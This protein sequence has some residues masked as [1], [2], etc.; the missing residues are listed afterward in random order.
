MSESARV[1][2]WRDAKRQKG[3]KPCTLWLTADEESL[4]KDLAAKR[5][6][7]PTEIM[8]QALAYF[9]TGKPPVT[10]IVTDIEQ[11]REMIQAEIATLQTASVLATAIATVTDIEQL[12]A[13][14]QDEL[15]A[16]AVVTATVT[17]MVTATLPALVRAIVEELALETLGLSATATYN[18]Y[19]TDIEDSEET[20]EALYDDDTDTNI[21]VSDTETHRQT[22]EE[23]HVDITDT[24]SNVIDTEMPTAAPTRPASK[25][26]VT[27]V[28]ASA[29][30]GIT[31]QPQARRKGGRPTTIRPRIMDLLRAH[32]EGL[33]AVE[34]KVH[35]GIDKNIGDTLSGMVR[36]RLLTKQG[37]GAQVRY[38]VPGVPPAPLA[39][40]AAPAPARRKRQTPPAAIPTA[41]IPPRRAARTAPRP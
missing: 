24:N 3:L 20:H 37:S 12:R 35:L 27:P 19:E 33:T 9:H 6:C 26:P 29:Q 18:S 11:L 15:A 36:N 2:R 4:L 7:S 10:A 14:I 38:R 17:A 8:Q 31:A 13:L 21:N 23:P 5:R 39:P 16:S 1:Q 22:S 30:N 41:P 25:R 34:I 40:P 32:P 28:P